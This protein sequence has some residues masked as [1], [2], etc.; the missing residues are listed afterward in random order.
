MALNFPSNPQV[1]DTY[2]VG[3]RTWKWTG[4]SWVVVTLPEYVHISV[5]TTAPGSP[6][7]GDLWID[8]N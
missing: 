4:T 8:T 7:T 1:N 5:G 6:S 3:D 2:T